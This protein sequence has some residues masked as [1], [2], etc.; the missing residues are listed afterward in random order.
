MKERKDNVMQA[1]HKAIPL[2]ILARRENETA[3]PNGGRM[4]DLR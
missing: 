2:D 1:T 4:I 3:A